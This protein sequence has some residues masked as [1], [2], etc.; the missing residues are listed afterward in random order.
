MGTCVDWS[1]PYADRSG[2][3]FKGNLH[4]HVSEG[5]GCASMSFSDAADAYAAEGFDFL[6]IADHYVLTDLQDPRLVQICGMEW[7]GL[8]GRHTGIYALDRDLIEQVRRTAEQSDALNLLSDKTA[9]TVVNHPRWI[10]NGIVQYDDAALDAAGPYDAMEI[11]N[12]SIEHGPGAAETA[13]CW[14]RA[15]TSGRRVLALAGD[16]AHHLPNIGRAFVMARA[17]SRTPESIF[18]AI[19]AGNCYA[20]SGVVLTDIRCE[21]D[22]VTVESEN[23]QE[24]RAICSSGRVLKMHD[25]PTLAFDLAKVDADDPLYV[26]FEAFGPGS[27]KAWTQPFFVSPEPQT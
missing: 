20:S 27:R 10:R 18:N 17:A 13:D 16:D 22:I 21:A 12:S 24:I 11:Y 9:L 26:R 25:G 15:L 14:D 3:W 19:R 4:T 2:R 1:N 5:S 7:T 8:D 23:A 6:A